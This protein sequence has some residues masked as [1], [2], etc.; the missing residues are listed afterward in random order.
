MLAFTSL[1][2][3]KVLVHIAGYEGQFSKFASPKGMK[4]LKPT[5]NISHQLELFQ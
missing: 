5:H 1:K 4:T 3:I 2:A